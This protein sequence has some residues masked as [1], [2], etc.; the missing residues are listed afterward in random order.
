VRNEKINTKKTDRK[1]GISAMAAILLVVVVVVVGFLA[2]QN[3]R[4]FE[5][6]IISQTQERLL[7]I[8]QTGAQD[9][10]A[11][12]LD[13]QYELQMLAENLRIERAV[14]NN[15]SA[16][17]ILETDGYSPE[18]ALY[19]HLNGVINGLYRLDAKGI[20]QSRIPFVE[21]REG[22]DFSHKPGVK[23]VLKTHK[24]YISESFPAASGEEC[25]SVCYPVFEQEQ[26]NGIVRVMVY[27]R[28]INNIIS[29]IKVGRKGYAQIIDDNGIMIAH[30]KPEH[31]G[32]DI[33]ATRR[34]AFPAYDW[35]ELENVA[36][37]M[38]NGEEGVGTYHSAWW[39]DEE[40]Q[41]VKKLTA[42]APIRLGNELWSISVSMDY[43]EVSGPVKVHSRNVAMG[44]GF[45]MLVFFAAG[46]WFYNIQKEK[47]K[48]AAKVES[49]EKLRTVNNHLETANQQLQAQEQQL[50][51]S[52]QQ[53]QAEINE[54]KQIDRALQESEEKYRTP[55]TEMTN[56]FAL[57]KIVVDEKGTP[58]DYIF[59]EVNDTFEKLT[60]LKRDNLI[61]KR[62]TEAL[63]GIEK[64]PTDWIGKY[65]KVALEGGN[66]RFENYSAPLEKWFSTYVYCPVKDHF[67][68]IFD[69]ITERKLTE[70]QLLKS[71][72]QLEET[73][74][75][76][77]KV[78]NRISDIM[79]S[80]TKE[81]GGGEK[82]RFENPEL[83]NCRQ[84]K[85]CDKTHCPAYRESE[86]VRCW[87]IAGTLCNGEVQGQYAKKI[88]DCDL[89]EVYQQARSNPICNLGESFNAMITVLADRQAEL[90][91]AGKETEEVNEHLIKPTA[92]ANDMTAQAEM[93]NMA[94]SQF[95]AN[96]SHE[97]RTP[98]NAIIGFSDLLAEEDLTEE[99]KA[100]VDI[101]RES[102][103]NL[104]ALINDILDFSK[105]EAGPLSTE[106]IDCPLARLFD[107]VGSLMRPKA[108]EK[109][110]EFEIVKSNGLPAQI[111]SDP[112]RLQQCLINLIGNATKF[113]RQGHVHVT[114]SLED[115]DNQ[116]YI[117]FD[118]ADTGIG[119]PKDKQERIF[120]SFTQADG[121][122]TRKYGGTGLGLTITK[123]LAELLGGELTLTSEP[124]KGS[125]FSLTIPANVDITKLP[126]LD[127]HNLAGSA[128]HSEA[129]AGQPGFSGNI[130][131]AED[132]PTNQILIKS[133]LE[134]SGLQ[135]TIA[136]DGIE[137]LQKASTQQ[138]DLIFMDMMM[139]HINGY[140]AARELRE[141][142]IETPV[143][144]V[145]ANAMKGDDK[146]CLE[147]GCDDYLAK[148]IDCRELLKMLEKYLSPTSQEEAG[149]KV[150]QSC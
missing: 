135:V 58:I 1:F 37:K 65:G 35:S 142:G 40:L 123:Q 34:E 81:G 108:T 86:P 44:A 115:K 54:C 75:N 56:G 20:I 88:K 134:R 39:Q 116:P 124:G 49:A 38:S 92:L 125:V 144:A 41:R 9:V 11:N 50:R 91:E 150:K 136:G 128:D 13:W 69:D 127:R 57:H 85:N 17:D 147:A 2:R 66:I 84:A 87:E 23:V 71:E 120:E 14:I 21:G 114:V 118:I 102:G 64:D 47:A 96:M 72:S 105:I 22:A 80:A 26:F 141:E 61:G 63:P 33:I 104:L 67:V 99:Q 45:L 117:R 89:C 24:P 52:N 60:G 126:L 43:D 145:T 138:F 12:V 19:K 18:I 28:S 31:I 15:E 4:A 16:Q 77:V 36:G 27:L 110:L 48:L 97:I 106:I 149:N 111:R 82:L 90:E 94:K 7:N 79:F 130:L 132:S 59:L 55:F 107:S 129:R 68:T 113:T 101:I 51:A 98:M 42:F 103:K 70:Q 32:K 133:L 73:N 139:P 137:A 95:L 30:P 83:V 122:T 6:T 143:I 3:A 148:P 78:A 93:A 131:V 146:K 29:N 74:R 121:D 140:E 119:I 8:A 100:D 46:G 25:F 53:L 76:L 112:T 5:N 109:G 62:V 10:Q